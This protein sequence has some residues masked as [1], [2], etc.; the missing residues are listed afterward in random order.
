MKSKRNPVRN[1]FPIG[2]PFLLVLRWKTPLF[3]DDHRRAQGWWGRVN[4][5]GAA[6]AAARV[7]RVTR[8]ASTHG[9]G[10]CARTQARVLTPDRVA[11]PLASVV[12]VPTILRMPPSLR[13][14]MTDLPASGNPLAVKVDVSV[15][16]PRE[17]PLPE[18]AERFVGRVGRE[19]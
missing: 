13:V 12:A 17:S 10:V 2:L 15:A 3:A 4:D 1:C 11:T 7:S 6:C 19:A 16:V 8:E 18:T 5:Q 9:S 14:K